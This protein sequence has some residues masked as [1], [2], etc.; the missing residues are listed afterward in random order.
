[1]FPGLDLELRGD[2]LS[3]PGAVGFGVHDGGD[4]VPA[5]MG[6]RGTGC[7]QG[8]V[9]PGWPGRV[10]IGGRDGRAD[11]AGGGDLVAGGFQGGGEAGTRRLGATHAARQPR[12]ARLT[13]RQARDS[14]RMGGGRGPVASGNGRPA[15][16]A[17]G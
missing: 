6:L 10:R 17:R 14:F 2:F 8:A 3:A 16:R 12:S 7:A 5:G 1:M 11:A 13:M 4:A 9:R 15:A